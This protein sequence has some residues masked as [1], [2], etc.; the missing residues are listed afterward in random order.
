VFRGTDPNGVWSLYIWDDQAE[1]ATPQSDPGF[2]GDG[3][4][5]NMTTADPIADLS[6]TQSAQPDPVRVGS[7]L[8]YSVTVSNRGPAAS[9]AVVLD[10][11][12]AAVIFVSA[13]TSR[14]GCTHE[15]GVVRCDLGNLPSGAFG[16]MTIEVTPVFGGAATN[17]ISVTGSQ[18]DLNLSNNTASVVFTVLATNDPPSL[19]LLPDVETSEDITAGPFS[20]TIGDAETPEANLVLDVTSTN[21][22]LIDTPGIQFDGTGTNRTLSLTPVPDQSGTA[23]LTISVTDEEGVSTRRS[24][25]FTVHPVNDPP[26]LNPL[27]ELLIAENSGR[28]TVALEGIS[29]GAAN[30]VQTLAVTA[31]VD[32]ANLIAGLAASYS[33][34][35]TTGTLRFL[36]VPNAHG[37]ARITVM[38]NDGQPINNLFSRDILVTIQ[39]ASQPP[40]PV[41]LAI[42]RVAN[43]VS[44]TVTTT[45]GR[46]YHLEYSDQLTG[47]N[48]SL[49]ET[50]TGTGAP[51]TLTDSTATGPTRFYRVRGE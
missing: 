29:S 1:N 46:P 14:G 48:W 27:A 23:L 28:Q 33:S 43:T 7:V 9:S 10:T 37:I 45:A 16:T 47:T 30:E 21:P 44:V 5:L 32:D 3:W 22:A 49:A 11:L 31:S 41:I 17:R 38:V 12:P 6:I 25:Q 24:F 18:L 15:N 50:K 36:P 19:P 42:S 2:I 20:F 13:N 34:P 4:T 26:T 35:E 40:E 51:L 39:P 8:T